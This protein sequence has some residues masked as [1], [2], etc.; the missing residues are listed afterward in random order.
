[1]GR[2]LV[3]QCHIYGGRIERVSLVRGFPCAAALLLYTPPII[4]T[5]ALSLLRCGSGRVLH[6]A[7]SQRRSDKRTNGLAEVNW[8][9]DAWTSWRL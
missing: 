7:R 4:P 8:V 5:F 2:S 9:N 6:N 1:M 3:R